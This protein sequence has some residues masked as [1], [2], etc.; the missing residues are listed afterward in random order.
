MLEGE[1]KMTGNES[2]DVEIESRTA[3][4]DSEPTGGQPAPAEARKFDGDTPEK[5]RSRMDAALS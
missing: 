1:T 4:D 5:L 3:T 2:E